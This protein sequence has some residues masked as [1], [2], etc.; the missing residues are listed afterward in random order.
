MYNRSMT[1][2]LKRLAEIYPVVGITGPRQAGKTTLARNVFSHLPY[3]SLEN[4]DNRLQ[5]KND[6]KFF[7]EKYPNGAIFDEIQHVPE[8]LSYLQQIVDETSE[9]GKYVVIGSQNFTLINNIAQSLPG[10]IGI[11]TLLPMSME[12]LGS[13]HK[14]DEYIFKGGYPG[15]HQLNMSTEEF[16]PFYIDT[17]VKRDIRQMLNINN[18]DAFEKFISLCAGRIG[19]VINYNSLARDAGISHTTAREWLNILKASFIVFTLSP[20]HNNFNKRVT[21]MPKLYFYDTGLAC[22]LLRLEKIEQVQNHYLRGG[23]FENLVM[24]EVMKYRMNK[25]KL[26]NIYFWRDKQDREIDLICDWGN[27][28]RAIEIKS[29]ITISSDYTKHFKY[30][31]ALSDNIEYSVIYGGKEPAKLN[32]VSINPITN[33]TSILE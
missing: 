19:Q 4:S 5:A 6:T 31:S 28:I 30:F 14:I 17:Y 1:S 7:L 25:G 18:L 22:S 15:L 16:Y 3:V 13:Q 27:K 9:K 10:R 8:I 11:A 24:L 32:N 29:G 23:L 21:K 20:Y 2:L 33:I 26:A 12:E